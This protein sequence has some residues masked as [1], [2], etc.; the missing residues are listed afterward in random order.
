MGQTFKNSMFKNFNTRY[1]R[2]GHSLIKTFIFF[3]KCICRY[4]LFSIP[5]PINTIILYLPIV[6]VFVYLRE[7]VIGMPFTIVTHPECS[8]AWHGSTLDL[9][10]IILLYLS[11]L[12]RYITSWTL[13]H[14]SYLRIYVCVPI[15]LVYDNILKC[16]FLSKSRV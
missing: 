6:I 1:S 5:T 16:Y 9:E 12:C 15:H 4:L 10:Y 7:C 2:L 14:A 3:F 13:C 11:A 8:Y